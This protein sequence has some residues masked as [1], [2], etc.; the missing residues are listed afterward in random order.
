MTEEIQTTAVA[1]PKRN[2]KK[3]I[4]VSLVVLIVLCAGIVAGLLLVRQPQD[5]R[6]DAAV[7]TGTAKLYLTPET[8]TISKGETFTATVLFD[9]AGIAISGLTVKLE[10]PYT[11]SEAPISITNVEINPSLILDN[12]WDFPYKNFAKSGGT[13][14]VEIAGLSASTGGYTTD[15][16]ENLATITF[17]GN[18]AGTINVVFNAMESVMAEKASGEDILLIPQSTGN[19][20]V[21]GEETGSPT[22]SPTSTITASAS[23][24]PTYSPSIPTSIPTA[25]PVPVTGAGAST[26][27]M[28]ATGLLLV[29]GAVALA[30]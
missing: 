25:P 1:K 3:T 6:E 10:Y 4:I 13:E 12:N 16:Q 2:T 19:Y 30:L 14:K 26:L 22:A 17:K 23:A 27:I 24:T 29:L 8:K 21:S 11:G 28:T 18:R 9:T 7:A 20:I 15:G 5:I